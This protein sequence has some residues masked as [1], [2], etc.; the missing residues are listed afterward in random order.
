[1]TTPTRATL[2]N[3]PL[4]ATLPSQGTGQRL[5]GHQSI[6]SNP[7]VASAVIA[8]SIDTIAAS[9][10]RAAL[11]SGEIEKNFKQVLDHT[12]NAQTA[13]KT[14]AEQIN[15]T[16]A[17]APGAGGSHRDANRA[18]SFSPLNL[19]PASMGIQPRDTPTAPMPSWRQDRPGSMDFSQGM[20]VG[21]DIGA[22]RQQGANTL[23][24]F[25]SNRTDAKQPFPMVNGKMT[26]PSGHPQAGMEVNEADMSEAIGST[27]KYARRFNQVATA[28]RAIDNFGG[29]RGLSG[30]L[31][32][33]T[34]K[35]G[36]IGLAVGVGMK[37]GS[38]FENQREENRGY[39]QIYGGSNT[40]GFA[41]RTSESVFSRLSMFG[42]M[43][44]GQAA[45][46]FKDVS[47][48][49]IQGDDRQA[50]LDFAVR[51]FRKSGMDTKLAVDLMTT[52]IRNGVKDFSD[53]NTSLDQ[54]S[55]A[56]R[57]AGVNVGEAQRAFARTFELVQSSVT[58]GSGA[59]S[60][61]GGLTAAQTALGNSVA[62][63][64]DI[65]GMVTNETALRRQATLLG[66]DS[67]AYLGGV[68]NGGIQFQPTLARGLTASLN[69]VGTDLNSQIRTRVQQ[70]KIDAVGKNGTLRN[71]DF[72]SFGE[73]VQREGLMNQT[74]LAGLANEMSAQTGT[75]ISSTDALSIAISAALGAPQSEITK[76]LGTSAS[77]MGMDGNTFD[78]R[79]INGKKLSLSNNEDQR[80]ALAKSMGV[81]FARPS[82]RG[83]VGGS[84]AQGAARTYLGQVANTGTRNEYEEALVRDGGNNKGLMVRVKSGDS[85]KM[86]SYEEALSN[87]DYVK[88]VMSGSVMVQNSRNDEGEALSDR[89]AREK[90]EAQRS[91]DAKGGGG[92]NDR[93]GEIRV[94]PTPL[95]QKFLSF[96]TYG[97]EASSAAR[98]LG[99][100]PSADVTPGSQTQ[101]A[102]INGVG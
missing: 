51:N 3:S 89:L 38:E 94:Y 27:E 73:T 1:M 19:S 28:Q 25:L 97:G 5:P 36:P 35:A 31:G 33:I 75:Q 48:L 49:G 15:K 29:G 63:K 77:G 58:A 2:P 99:Q 57:K 79:K 86:V 39:Q 13:A 24:R 56:A 82:S 43:G 42:T 32:M 10:Q 55:T 11:Y 18:S 20:N 98:A 76:A 60:L 81:V 80:N 26:Y 87:P 14:V 37:I 59:A 8:D 44:Q 100:P 46:L 34:K 40:S 83:M 54:V 84:G 68:R 22:L 72:Q 53:L 92:K 17:G 62:G 16:V 9:V 95:L 85:T 74:D 88:Q 91:R 50:G 67:S 41:Q 21:R 70:L 90:T 66:M 61:A 12:K 102:G 7:T 65:R 47:S 23:N 71:S 6:V 30:A 4:A 93:S 78:P 96:Q 69:Q 101:A 45:Q 64:L 52:S